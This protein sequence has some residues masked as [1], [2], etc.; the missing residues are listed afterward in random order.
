M[1]KHSYNDINNIIYELKDPNEILE[2]CD[3]SKSL[4]LLV[5]DSNSYL[6]SNL[7]VK[8]F[9]EYKSQKLK[10]I[11]HKD[12]YVLLYYCEKMGILRFDFFLKKAQSLINLLPKIYDGDHLCILNG[13]V[14]TAITSKTNNILMYRQIIPNKNINCIKDEKNYSNFSYGGGNL[15]ILY[16]SNID[17]DQYV[18]KI[19][20]HEEMYIPS[21][22][23]NLVYGLYNPNI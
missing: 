10:N 4:F 16:C 3:K 17:C 21:K 13:I 7:I 2:K 14:N 1:N 18:N 8:Y 19:S 11:S 6:W 12:F 23:S 9:N 15:K 22:E 20:L 5:E